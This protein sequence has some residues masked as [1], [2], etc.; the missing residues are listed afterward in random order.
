MTCQQRRF[1][2]VAVFSLFSFLIGAILLQP[3]SIS[4]AFEPGAK[5]TATISKKINADRVDNLH[6][7]KTPKADTLLALDANSAF[8]LGVIPQGSGSGLDADKLDGLD[9]KAFQ[10]AFARIIVLPAAPND[11]TGNGNALLAAL[12]GITNAT[13][14]RPYLVMLEPGIYDVGSTP[15][16]MKPYVDIEGSGEDTTQIL[17]AG[18]ASQSTATVLG[19]NNTGLRDLTVR[20]SGG[21]LFAVAIYNSA[22]SPRLLNVTAEASGGSNPYDTSNIAVLNANGSSPLMVNVSAFATSTVGN[23]AGINNSDASSPT[24]I[25]V[26]AIATGTGNSSNYGIRNQS[27]SLTIRFSVMKGGGGTFNYGLFDDASSGA[28]IQ[29]LNS[30]I[31]GSLN[32]ITN[33]TGTTTEVANSKIAGGVVANNSGTLK[34]AGIVDENFAFYNNSCP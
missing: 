10:N 8:P 23:N 7:A 30:E 31:E 20:N 25:N 14:S 28:V 16:Q 24:I 19:A 22:A 1:A 3:P 32:S 21:N 29:V 15:L 27:S 17:G 5:A 6:A 26:R 2:I 9:S 12:S 11:A 4:R 13:S 34:C 18:N 33:G